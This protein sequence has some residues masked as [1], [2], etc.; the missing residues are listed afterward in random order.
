M[1]QAELAILTGVSK[2]TVSRL[3]NG[4]NFPEWNTIEKLADALNVTEDHFLHYHPIVGL[5]SLPPTIH[6]SWDSVASWME[7]KLRIEKT[8]SPLKRVLIDRLTAADDDELAHVRDFFDARDKARREVAGE[9]SE[10]H[11]E[12]GN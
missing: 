12:T 11:G 5:E 2:L 4:E 9:G 6:E 3:E 10:D 1:S 7:Q 8:L